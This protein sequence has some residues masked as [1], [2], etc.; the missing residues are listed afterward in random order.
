MSGSEEMITKD[1]EI[2][3]VKDH[4]EVFLAGVFQ[5][6]ADDLAEAEEEISRLEKTYE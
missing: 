5:F 4:Y 6:S 2:R 3:P 1:Y